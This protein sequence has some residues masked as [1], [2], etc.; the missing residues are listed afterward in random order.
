MRVQ[1]FLH[2]TAESAH[3]R[4]DFWS[5]DVLSQLS[6]DDNSLFVHQEQADY[7]SSVFGI[8]LTVAGALGSV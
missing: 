8:E 2:E 4:V 3:F 1:R 7:A 6:V 5:G